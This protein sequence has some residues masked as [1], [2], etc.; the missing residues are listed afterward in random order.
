MGA[1]WD[2]VEKAFGRSVFDRSCGRPEL[3]FRLMWN[4]IHM[5]RFGNFSENGEPWECL[6]IAR[7]SGA[8]LGRDCRRKGDRF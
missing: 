5:S 7:H 1:S 6:M 2:A 4:R 3:R 8:R